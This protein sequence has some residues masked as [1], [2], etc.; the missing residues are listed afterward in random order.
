MT[1]VKVDMD[2]TPEFEAYMEQTWPKALAKLKM[3]CE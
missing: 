1:E 3:T 2:V